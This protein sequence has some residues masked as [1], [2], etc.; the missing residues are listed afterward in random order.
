MSG[1]C[2]FEHHVVIAAVEDRW[3][4]AL[5]THLA[6]CDDCAAAMAVAPWMES[7]S[8]I[9]ERPRP[10]PNPTIIWLKAQLLR[11]T[12]AASRA[13]RP[14]TMF[15]TAAYIIVA[16]GW[17]GLITWKW[18]AIYRMMTPTGLLATAAETAAASSLPVSMYGTV[19]LLATMT[20]TLGLHT[21]LAED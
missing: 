6:T 5:R 15:Q 17:A 3:T 12:A 10:L 16:A 14:V 19:V 11:N 21:I 4:E 1:S 9:E 8:S 20:V 18:D 13:A 2:R 7:L